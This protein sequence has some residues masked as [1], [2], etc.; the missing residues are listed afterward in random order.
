MRALQNLVRVVEFESTG[1]KDTSPPDWPATNYGLHSVLL[2]E[3]V[4]E[5]RF[6]LTGSYDTSSQSWPATNYSLHP[7]ISC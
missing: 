4:G 3:M 2:L 7:D 5:V 6:E 1:S